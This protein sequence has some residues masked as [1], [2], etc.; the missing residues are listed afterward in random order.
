MEKNAKKKKT[1]LI[2]GI[3]V[4][5]LVVVYIICIATGNVRPAA[6]AESGSSGVNQS[7]TTIESGVS[8]NTTTNE[9]TSQEGSSKEPENI[10]EAYSITLS[11]GH[12]TAGV[13]FPAGKYNLSAVSG[14][15]NVSSSNMYSGGLNEIMGIKDDDMYQKSFNGAVLDKGVVLN[16]GGSL[17]LKL[18]SDAA[19]T[20]NMTSRQNTATEEYTLSAGNYTCGTDFEPGEYVITAVSG[21]GNV[22]SDN[23][24]DGGLNEIMGTQA[25][26]TYITTFNN[27]TFKEGNVI[28]ISGVT[29]KLT[30]SK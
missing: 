5:V 26:D 22:S 20:N 10:T 11:A 3:V 12:Y 13:D 16:I 8:Q 21:S 15:G 2:V 23:L 24:Y 18:D 30:P 27:A 17:Q 7:E 1:L 9:K 25:D 28:T 29:I 6:E 14:G 4:A 19:Q